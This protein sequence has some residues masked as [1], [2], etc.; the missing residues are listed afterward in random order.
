MDKYLS[1]F[2]DG[3]DHESKV[4]KFQQIEYVLKKAIEEG[5]LQK[6]SKL[7]SIRH[8]SQAFLISK[9][10]TERAYWRLKKQG[11]L[12]HSKGKGYFVA[13]LN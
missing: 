10:T 11:Y 3:I 12:C 5:R 13:P 7:P 9:Q 2:P 4:P 8:L 1:L 6:N